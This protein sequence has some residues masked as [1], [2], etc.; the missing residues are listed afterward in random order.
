MAKWFQKT[1]VYSVRRTACYDKRSRSRGGGRI[2]F[3]EADERVLRLMGLVDSIPTIDIVS[4]HNAFIFAFADSMKW[5]LSATGVA[6]F[7]EYVTM[8]ERKD[9]RKQEWKVT[10][11][12]P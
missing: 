9:L 6:R 1:E 5:I 4:N 3:G 2:Q 12:D 11:I 7:G 10:P 8:V